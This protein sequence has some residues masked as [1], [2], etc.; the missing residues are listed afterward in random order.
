MIDFKNDLIVVRNSLYNQ[1][2]HQGG[3]LKMTVDSLDISQSN[4]V[5]TL[6]NGIG[7]SLPSSF[8]VQKFLYQI[9]R[10]INAP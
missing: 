8:N 7:T 6:P 4:F 2:V 9:N 10:S 5:S 3:A 1:S